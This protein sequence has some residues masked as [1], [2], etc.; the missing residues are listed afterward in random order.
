MIMC[1]LL[2]C[3]KSTHVHTH[4][5]THTCTHTH[6]HTCTHAH[7]CTHTHILTYAC[8]Y[9][10]TDNTWRSTITIN[11]Y[12][13]AR[14]SNESQLHEECLHTHTDTHTHAHTRVYAPITRDNQRLQLIATAMQDLRTKDSWTKNSYT[15]KRCFRGASADFWIRPAT[16]LHSVHDMAVSISRSPQRSCMMRPGIG[17]NTSC[18]VGDFA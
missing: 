4:R 14:F 10:C 9:L 8:T 3:T 5:H 11:C 2:S 17:W 18:T 13:Y 16:W 7:T 15:K 6:M 12:S 1:L